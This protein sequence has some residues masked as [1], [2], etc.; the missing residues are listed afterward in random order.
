M[1]KLRDTLSRTDKILAPLTPGKAF[2][3][4]CCGPTVYAPAHIGNFRTFLIQ[5]VLRRV[6]E[7]DGIEVCHVRN[8]TDV[9]DKTIRRSQEQGRTLSDFTAIWTEKFH[10]DCRELN[11]LPP[12]IEPSAV[13]HIPLQIEMIAKLIEHGHAYVS[14]DG[15]VY[16]KVASDPHYGKF[17]DVSTLQ[18]QTTNSAGEANSADEYTRDNVADFALWKARKPEDGPNFWQSPWG[19][20][21]P[22]WHIECS[23]MSTHYLGETFELHGGGV[24]LCFPHHENEIAQAECSCEHYGSFAQQWFHSAHLMVDGAKMSKSLGNLYTLDDLVNKGFAPMALRYVLISGHYR[25]QLNFTLKSLDDAASALAKIEKSV[26]K[27]LAAAGMSEA[28]FVAQEPDRQAPW[29]DF[30]RA[31]KTLGNDLNVSGALGGIFGAVASLA[32]RE[33]TPEEARTQLMGLTK[34]LWALGLKLFTIK[35]KNSVPATSEAADVPAE[36]AAIGEQRWA[37]KIAKNWAESDRLRG[38]LEQRGWKSLDRKDGY[39]LVK[40]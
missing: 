21:R 14:S 12:T 38:E 23:A 7:S 4:Y 32:K 17:V 37:A 19:E 6:L 40:I 9:D 28:D 1:V 33:M 27:I 5:D 15:S 25:S 11:M 29:G 35:E 30:E 8:I 13:A 2:G 34:I 20:G 3:M 18:T 24:D 31:W 16:F 26:R 22:G 39:T 10:K 36:I